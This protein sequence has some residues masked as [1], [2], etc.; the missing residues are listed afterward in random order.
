MPTISNATAQGN[1]DYQEDR[2]VIARIP[3]GT[4]LAIADGHGGDVVAEYISQNLLRTWL[5]FDDLETDGDTLIKKVFAALHQDTKHMHSGST[6]SLAFIDDTNSNVA[7]AVLGDSPVMVNTFNGAL[8]L[9][10][11]HNVR[12]NLEERGQALSRGGFYAEG[13]LWKNGA[14]GLQ[15]S[16]ALGDADLDGI[17]NREPEISVLTLTKPSWLLVASDGL[18]DPSHLVSGSSYKEIANR[19]DDG[20]EAQ[21]LVNLAVRIRT[22]DN[23]SAIVWRNK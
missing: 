17:L 19:L 3:D 2:L 4:L 5:Q 6:L 18:I 21:D 7:V 1:R 23:A 15:M 22:N 8:W 9:A 13:Y 11:E 10:R 16:R 14:H 12:T 20:A